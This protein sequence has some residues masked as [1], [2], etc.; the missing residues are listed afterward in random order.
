MHYCLP[1]VVDAFST[2]AYNW[3]LSSVSAVAATTPA[4]HGGGGR[5]GGLGMNARRLRRVAAGA[6]GPSIPS[7]AS[8]ASA[9]R[10]SFAS[11]DAR[12]S[13]TRGGATSRRTGAGST[14]DAGP[15]AAPA[16]LGRAL[17]VA[18][19]PPTLDELVN[20]SSAP[21]AETPRHN[22]TTVEEAAM[23]NQA[24][25]YGPGSTPSIT[26]ASSSPSKSGAN[27]RPRGSRFF[28]LS[29]ERWLGERGAA[30]QFER[31][32]PGANS[33]RCSP[34]PKKLTHEWWWAFN[35][36]SGGCGKNCTDRRGGELL[37]LPASR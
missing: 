22:H 8:G 11:D 28:S 37:V 20:A 15:R 23:Q 32:A 34:P 21:D 18:A 17:R 7:A 1:G 10:A 26:T 19:H 2:L 33:A 13:P 25:L 35:C 6:R 16:V 5:G 36:G 14:R 31:C 30:A 4:A 27:R 3:L 12:P 9:I 24:P 29:I